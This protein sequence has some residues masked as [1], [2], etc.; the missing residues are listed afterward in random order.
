MYMILD[1]KFPCLGIVN[2]YFL[3]APGL[4]ISY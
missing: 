4:N 3:M 2:K 1:L